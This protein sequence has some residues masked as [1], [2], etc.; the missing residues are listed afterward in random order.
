MRSV[1]V[2]LLLGGALTV[3]AQEDVLR[4]NGRPGAI[5]G[6]SSSTSTSRAPF[7]IGIEGGANFNF[8]GQGYTSDPVIENSPEAALESGFGVSP[9]F[10][11]FVDVGLS[12]TIGL[13]FR[14]AYDA[15]AASGSKDGIIDA[16]PQGVVEGPGGGRVDGFTITPMDV[17]AEHSLTANNLAIALLLRADLTENLFVTFGPIMHM[18]MGDVTRTDKVTKIGPEDTW[19]TV[20][21]DLNPGQYDMIERE[22]TVAQN[23]LPNASGLNSVAEYATSRFGL[24]LG[25]G[26]RF[27]LSKSIY[28]APN[29]RYQ[30]MFT[31]MNGE[32]AAVDLS[33]PFSQST[34]ALTYDPSTLNTLA[35][36]IQ[37]GFSL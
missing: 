13:Q 32:F 29:L 24:E 21:Y 8:F 30:Y 18:V 34:A 15:K 36:I 33:Q 11:V 16:T 12:R 28:L 37:L 23:L 26:Y 7:V 10:G 5:G 14:L 3:S 31:P 22:T 6:T 35:L 27:A 19:I 20:D 25:L 9:E 2:A 4:P 1:V 17:T